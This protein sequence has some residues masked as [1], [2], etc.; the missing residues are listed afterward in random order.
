MAMKRFLLVAALC[1]AP[2]FPSSAATR[3]EARIGAWDVVVGTDDASGRF[4][5]CLALVSYRNGINLIFSIDASFR[6]TMVLQNSAWRLSPG[7][8]YPINYWIDNGPTIPAN[9]AVL[10][11]DMVG[12]PLH[13]STALFD[14]FKRGRNLTIQ[15]AGSQFDFGLKDSSR[16]LQST[17]ECTNRYAGSSG[18]GSNPFSAAPASPANVDSSYKAEAAMF[19]ANL[20][21]AAGIPGFQI[22]E[23]PPKGFENYHSAFVS[24][25]LIGGLVIAPGFTVDAAANEMQAAFASGCNGKLA[26]A[27]SPVEGAGTQVQ[28]VCEHLDGLREEGSFFV[29]PRSKGGVYSVVITQAP[30]APP[31]ASS[32]PPTSSPPPSAPRAPSQAPNDISG[33]LLDAS[34]KVAR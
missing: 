24:P 34:M 6:W 25:D 5:Q 30:A 19:T 14:L 32:L 1:A 3:V 17:L 15:A 20:L 27:K 13:D 2:L 10:D 8:T 7:A 11:P 28:V 31:A 4:A 26:T 29:I 22:V 12:V 18:G 21:S 23:T 33:K 16:A 9:A